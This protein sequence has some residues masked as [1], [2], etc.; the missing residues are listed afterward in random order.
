[1]KNKKYYLFLTIVLLIVIFA[2]VIEVKAIN[3]GFSTEEL[4]EEDKTT[5]LSNISL[6]LIKEEPAQKAI[7]CFDVNSN[8]AIAI[9]QETIG[10]RKTISVYS[11]E[12]VFQYGYT[13]NSSGSFGVE[14]DEENLNIYF[15][16]SDVIIS[17][18]SDGN[19]LGIKAV[20]DTRDNNSH[21]NAMLYSDERIVGETT[22]LIRNDMGILNWVAT[23]YSQILTIDDTGYERIIYDVNSMQLSNMIVTISFIS[24][25]LL[26][27]IVSIARQ[28][29]K[30]K[31]SN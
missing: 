10:R 13:F 30:L 27:A 6:S 4:S 8:H 20:V 9:G 7:E 3:T 22:Y 5:F 19:V 18:D 25:F 12:G 11:N 1:M 2:S 16:R 23:S 26:I 14:W 29:I 24:V 21:R 31:R 28:F 15:V 17:L